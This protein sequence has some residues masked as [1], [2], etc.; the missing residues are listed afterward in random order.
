MNEPI[1]I[2][3]TRDTFDGKKWH[4]VEF[5]FMAARSTLFDEQLIQWAERRDSRGGQ[6]K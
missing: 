2:P 5:A 1:L 6:G 4:H 3:C